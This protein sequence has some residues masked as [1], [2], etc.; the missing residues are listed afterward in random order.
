MVGGR[1]RQDDESHFKQVR[2]VNLGEIAL[3]NFGLRDFVLSCG[4]YYH[5]LP[6]D[7]QILLLLPDL[8]VGLPTHT[9][10]SLFVISFWKFLKVTRSKV[11]FSYSSAK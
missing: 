8:A 2:Q 9:V 7:F 10:K 6:K 11:K 5:T 4:F 3:E 1:E